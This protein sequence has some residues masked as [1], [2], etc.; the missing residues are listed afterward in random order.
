[1]ERYRAI[2]DRDIVYIEV[3]VGRVKVGPLSTMID[4][5]GSPSWTIRYDEF[6]RARMDID[7]SDEGLTID[8]R[9]TIEAMTFSGKF[10]KTLKSQP[11]IIQGWGNEAV[12]PRLGLFMGRLLENLEYGVR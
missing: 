2:V 3:D 8:V 1:M 10:L 12:S 5:I 9:D 6:D 7:T 4:I 11:E